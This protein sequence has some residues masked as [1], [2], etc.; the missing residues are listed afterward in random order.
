[1]QFIIITG[2]SGAGKSVALN[3]LEDIGVYCVDNI[4]PH[5][6]LSLSQL[7]DSQEDDE[8][9][10]LVAD[11]RSLKRFPSASGSILEFR[12]SN[13]NCKVVFLD[14]STDEIINRYKMTRRRHPLL[15]ECSSLKEA[16]EEERRILAKTKAIADI[17]VDTSLLSSQQLKQKLQSLFSKTAA[18]SLLVSCVSF[19][20]KYGVPSDADLVFDVRC[21]PNPFYEEALHPLSGLDLPVQQYVLSSDKTQGFFTRLLDLIDYML[22]LYQKDESKSQLTIAIG[23]TGGRHRSVTIAEQLYHHLEKNHYHAVINHRDIDRKK[24]NH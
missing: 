10:A 17:V 13:P 2:M 1:M 19:G 8:K 24:F 6:F 16:I 22:P 12:R 23:C 21:L 11:V 18:E 3:S 9:I 15:E 5:L 14:A 20:F 4:P 7:C